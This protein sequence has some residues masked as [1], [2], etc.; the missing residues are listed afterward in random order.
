[1]SYEGCTEYLCGK[2]HYWNVDV[3]MEK[4][5]EICPVCGG[6]PHYM[7]SINQTN[8]YEAGDPSTFSA[9][10]KQIGYEDEWRED[11]Y[12]TRYAIKIPKYEPGTG[13]LDVRIQE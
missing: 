3:Y 2:G 13:W 1:M 5:Q 9:A 7:H 6:L 10:T 8:G 4:D 11:H 12:G